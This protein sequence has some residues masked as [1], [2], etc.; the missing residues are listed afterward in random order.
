MTCKN[1]LMLK[2]FVLNPTKNDVYGEA[3]RKA[4]LTYADHI[5]QE[6]IEFAYELRNWEIGCRHNINVVK[7]LGSAQGQGPLSDMVD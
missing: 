2:Y 4:L 1:G 3:S 6:N 7:I 5:Q